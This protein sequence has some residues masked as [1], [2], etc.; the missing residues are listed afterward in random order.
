MKTANLRGISD[1]Q[2]DPSADILNRLTFDYK[3]TEQ[4]TK[5]LLDKAR[6]LPTSVG[7]ETALERVSLV[8]R[9]LRDHDVSIEKFR[10]AEK[11]YYLRGGEAVDGFFGTIRERLGKTMKILLSRID[12]YQQEKLERAR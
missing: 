3:D 6:A 9:E 5:E 11:I 1:N 8:V 7:S 4:R 10:K 2:P 12:E